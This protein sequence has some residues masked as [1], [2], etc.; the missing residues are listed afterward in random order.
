MASVASQV[1]YILNKQKQIE[2]LPV[3]IRTLEFT[4]LTVITFRHRLRSI[5][6]VQVYTLSGSVYTLDS[7]ASIA[8]T[9]KNTVVVTFGSATDGRVICMA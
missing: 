3:R 6:I 1:N 8:C 2:D 7:T 4:G 9:D 5:P